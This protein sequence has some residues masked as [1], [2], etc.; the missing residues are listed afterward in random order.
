MIYTSYSKIHYAHFIRVCLSMVERKT[1]CM[2]I[3]KIIFIY[4]YL[5]SGLKSINK[6]IIFIF[7]REKR[8]TLFENADKCKHINKESAWMLF[9]DRT[10]YVSQ[11]ALATC[12]CTSQNWSCKDFDVFMRWC[13]RN[14]SHLN[15]LYF[16]FITVLSFMAF[17]SI[18][19]NRLSTVKTSDYRFNYAQAKR[20]YSWI[21]QTNCRWI[22]RCISYWRF[23][24]VL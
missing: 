19:W 1:F 9:G 3:K 21:L 15:E 2:T 11:F 4:Q 20:N 24:F 6:N 7:D 10:P 17:S 14:E 12:I 23:D 8:I 5:S 18:T 22:S 16:I 13:K